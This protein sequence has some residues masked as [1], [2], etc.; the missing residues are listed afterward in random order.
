[1]HW[2]NYHHLY[3]FWVVAREGSIAGA[4]AQLHVS[5]PTISH[6]LQ[7]LER[8]VGQPLFDR[9]GRGLTLTATGQLVLGYADSIFQLGQELQE[10]VR[11]A[12]TGQPLRLRVGIPDG[13]AKLMVYRLLR[14]AFQLKEPLRLLAREGPLD[15]LLHQLAAHELD[16]VLSDAPATS[17]VNVRAFNHPLGQCG[18]TFFGTAALVRRFQAGFPQTL[19]R[20]PLLLPAGHAMLRRGLDHWFDAQELTPRLVG[21]F[22]DS[23][24]MKVFGQEGRGLFPAPAAIADEVERQYRVRR[25]GTIEAVQERFYAI[26]VE[27]RLKHPAVQ[28]ISREAKQELL[29]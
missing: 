11:G 24:L 22:D 12:P 20:A 3:Y 28:A 9:V 13:L 1:M 5:Q 26:T 18:V 2:L 7:L 8:A 25:V 4:C 6:Q 27:R 21:E 15:R 23:A 14:P 10:A 16:L 19:D 29:A 17:L